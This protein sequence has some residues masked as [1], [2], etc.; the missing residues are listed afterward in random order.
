MGMQ[1]PRWRALVKLNI[2]TLAI[3]LLFAA[4]FFAFSART[5]VWTP[6]RIAGIS[7]TALGLV[8]LVIARLQ[9][10]DAFSVKARASTLVTTGLYSRIRNPIYVSAGIVILGAIVFAGRPWWLLVFAVMIPIQVYRSR[11]EARVLEEKFGSAYREYRQK[12]WF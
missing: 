5:I 1:V 11:N 4:I 9:L 2:V 8:L 6:L 10:G 3:L 12:T 7:L